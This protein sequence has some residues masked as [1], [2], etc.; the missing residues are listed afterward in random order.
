MANIPVTIMTI[1]FLPE[2]RGPLNILCFSDFTILYLDSLEISARNRVVPF[3][4]YLTFLI[5][6]RFTV[7]KWFIFYKMSEFFLRAD[8]SNFI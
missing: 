5:K 8:R 1:S 6:R 4:L 2:N 7:G 3:L